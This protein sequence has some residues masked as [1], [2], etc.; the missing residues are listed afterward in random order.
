MT[1]AGDFGLIAGALQLTIPSYAFRLVRRFGASRVGWFVTTAFSA[2]ALVNLLNLFRP[3]PGDSGGITAFNLICLA[4]SLLL[5]IGMFHVETLFREREK[6][7]M[8]QVNQDTEWE[9]KVQTATAD[10]LR[11]N[12][13]LTHEIA[14]R[15][16]LEKTLA[17]SEAQFRGL[18]NDNPLP[19][20]V[21]DVSS[22]R[23]LS[24][25]KAAL[26]QYGYTQQEFMA[27]SAQD[28]L[29]AEMVAGFLEDFS[30]YRLGSE[31]R[32]QWQH[33]RRDES[34]IDVEVTTLD[35]KYA[36][37]AARLVLSHDVTHRHR[38]EHQV[39]ESQKMEIA[40][41]V[42]SGAAEHFGQ[43]LTAIDH[44][45]ALLVRKSQ[46]SESFELL[47]RITAT[48][49]RASG[50][51]RQLLAVGGEYPV[52]IEPLDANGLVRQLEPILRRLVGTNVSVQN[53]YGSAMLPAL[54]DRY[55]LEHII[56][57]LVLNARDAMPSGGT[58]SISTA[59]VRAERP[60][61]WGAAQAGRGEY[62]CLMIRD[63]GRGIAPE[64]RS[65]LFEPFIAGASGNTMGLGLAFVRGAL[66]QQEGWAELFSEEGSGT[67]VRFF[68]PTTPAANSPTATILKGTVMLVEPEDRARA[69]AR[70]I[71]NQNGYR[72]IEADSTEVALV[73]WEGQGREVTLLMT[74]IELPGEL[75]G[76]A[77]ADRLREVRPDL[78]VL[79]SSGAPPAETPDPPTT[80]G[81]AIIRKP[82][83]PGDLVNAVDGVLTDH[84]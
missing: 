17:Q 25:N 63:T 10:L 70:S 65:R 62:F 9:S 80:E 51:A 72:V 40:A 6:V 29:P 76:Y 21:V 42:A 84:S 50:L 13:E 37:V 36:G 15:E 44:D 83:R 31:A 5:L 64:I 77:L 27:M 79:F 28:L 16:H 75:S 12:Q 69:L 56:V 81:R 60:V 66:R 23:F 38:Q 24:V 2:L 33:R 57:N 32:G 1:V 20:W 35:L 7:R 54:A 8:H 53:T 3:I 82:F 19:M 14:R 49:T 59:T 26:R 46:D 74:G 78:K 4:S 61:E 11:T 43:L 47:N 55:L 22:G 41:Q 30:K 52:N 71:L 39:R 34:R 67:E 68:L 73:L 48:T 58:L 45:T 18:F